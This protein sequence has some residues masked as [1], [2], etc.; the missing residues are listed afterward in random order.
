M[1]VLTCTLQ[2]LGPARAS[3]LY[4]GKH[5][6]GY[7]GYSIQRGT[8]PSLN[9]SGVTFKTPTSIERVVYGSTTPAA[10][11]PLPQCVCV[12]VC[13][14]ASVQVCVRVRVRVRVRECVQVCVRVRV[15]ASVCVCA[16][17]C[18]RACVCVCVCAR[19]SA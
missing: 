12:C 17:V 3:V 14:C 15:C 18:V 16:N 10:P 6:C 7:S 5:K 8:P 9:E 1:Y 13:E 19:A 4:S 11:C 2:P